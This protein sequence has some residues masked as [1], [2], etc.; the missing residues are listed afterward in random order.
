MRP[1]KNVE[2]AAVADGVKPGLDSCAAP[3]N[4][5]RTPVPHTTYVL[6]REAAPG[7]LA[8]L[9]TKLRS[10]VAA[11]IQKIKQRTTHTT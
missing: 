11:R 3:E 10:R 2:A 7:K 1:S 9:R 5:S 4:I 8:G 6:Q